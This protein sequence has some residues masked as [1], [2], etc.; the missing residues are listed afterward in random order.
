[1]KKIFEN[2]KTKTVEAYGKMMTWIGDKMSLFDPVCLVVALLGGWLTSTISPLGFLI[3]FLFASLIVV[4][5][6][7]YYMPQNGQSEKGKFFVILCG[8]IIALF[9]GLIF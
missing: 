1:M 6:Y 9:F 4:A 2:I 7:L 8:Q 3:Q 5:S